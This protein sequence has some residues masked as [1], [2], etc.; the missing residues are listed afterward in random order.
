MNNV[1]WKSRHKERIC[2]RILVG[3]SAL[4]CSK[5]ARERKKCSHRNR[6]LVAMEREEWV[7]RSGVGGSR[8][9]GRVIFL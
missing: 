1:S 4:V 3:S 2:C 5:K 9:L 8:G 7:L 6:R